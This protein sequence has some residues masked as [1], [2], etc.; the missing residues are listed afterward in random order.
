M[1]QL[2]TLILAPVSYTHLDVY[3]RQDQ[4]GPARIVSISSSKT[5]RNVTLGQGLYGDQSPD[6]FMARLRTTQTST[7]GLPAVVTPPGAAVTSLTHVVY[8]RRAN[9]PATLYVNGQDRGVLDIGGPFSSWDERM[10]LLLANELSEDRPWLG[11]Y[12]LVA[13]YDRAL[14]AAEVVHNYEAGAGNDSPI[15][16]SFGLLS[17]PAQGVA[18]H[19]VEFDS[20]ESSAAAGI[21][22]HFWEFGDGQT[23]NRPNPSY[24]YTEPG[25][26]TVSLTITDTAG[27]T[28]KA[29]KEGYIVV[30]SSPIPPL[31]AEFARFVLVDVVT[32]VVV[33]FGL[34]YPDLRC[35]VMWNADPAHMLLFNHLD[36]MRHACEGEQVKLVWVDSLEVA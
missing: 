35:T 36:D 23:S 34:Q 17:G 15:V 22:E 5:E 8:T 18:P 30:V 21:A 20:S 24:T 31:P 13:I 6:L 29:T 16:V 10:P 19:T 26:Y 32:A 3:K 11:T 12:Y 1:R 28:A 25:A 7:N 14:T 9:G 27:N 33:G 2:V 4:D